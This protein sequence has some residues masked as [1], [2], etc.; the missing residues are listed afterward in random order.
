MR[1]YAKTPTVLQ[2]EATECGAAS[3][4]MVMAYYG[5]YIPLEQMRI[6]TAVSRDGVNAAD[7][8]RAAKRFGLDCHGYRKEPA[9]LKAFDM[10]CIIHW[11]FNHFVVLEGFKGT[12]VYLNDP[13]VGRRKL[14]WD[15]FDEGF[16][17][18]VLTFKRTDSFV[19][20]KK[21]GR[22]LP[23]VRARLKNQ[24]PV[25]AK[26]VYIGFLMIVPGLILPSLSQI[27]IDDIL[28]AGYKDWL[29]RFLV[30]M[31][32]CLLVRE[33]LSYY[34]SMILVK[35]K[36]KLSLVSGYKFL[37][38]ML[39]L[40]I[41]F[42]DQRYVGDLVNRMDNNSDINDFLAGNFAETILNVFTVIFY[43]AILLLYSPVLSAIGLC[44]ILVSILVAFYANKVVAAAT[45]KMQ[46][47]GGKLYGALCAGVNITDTI[48]SAGVEM[49]YSNRLIGHQAVTA[50]QEQRLKRFQQIVGAI[51]SSVSQICDVLTLLFGSFMVIRGEFSPG[52]LIAFNALFDSFQEPVNKLIGFFEGLQKVKS[53]ILRV[54]DIERYPGDPLAD[55]QKKPDS[56]IS[57][58]TKLSGRVELKDVSFGYSVQKP[59][60]VS[61]FSFKLRSG[62]TI[63]FVGPSGCGKST[64]SKV[65]S[66]LYH[67]WQGQILFDGIPIEQIPASLL[68]ASV[69]TVS[70]SISLF[71]G[72]IRDNLT[73][74]NGA[75]PEE[76]MIAAAKDACIHDFIMKLPGGYD[77]KLS[78]GAS[79]LSGGQRQRIEIARALTT[80][81]SILIMDEATSAL[82]PI[83]EKN[84]LDNLQ[85]RGCTCVVVAH[86]LS[87][88]RD[89]NEIV[90]MSRGKI[91]QRGTH[92]T[93]RNEDGFYRRF[94]QDN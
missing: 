5:H 68:H 40:P 52:T 65:I 27:F 23:F 54:D 94:I 26:L 10:P 51:P 81:P 2:M 58:M 73:M 74:W 86:R 66:G 9:D 4:D 36:N 28:M 37:A 15:E 11:N 64:I 48:K 7:M 70:Q 17:G 34:R 90:V 83:V 22:M 20:E 77:Y 56:D 75:V 24:G 89:S 50:S 13:A 18:V 79:N 92:E 59:P 84:I 55:S 41:A 19:R 39:R 29:F 76:D 45:I 91:I 60:T 42:F 93:L 1:K 12:Y 82:D 57:R 67:P 21:K 69:S 87:A 43:L 33:G 46:M 72:T 8:M 63:A 49:E 88:F 25:L 78:E 16:T 31:G 85:R 38:H 35:L 62:E 6:E 14:T 3:L 32:G 61:G 53:N 30:F 80:N 71:S 44:G 47:S